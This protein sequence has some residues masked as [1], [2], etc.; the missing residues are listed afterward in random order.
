MPASCEQRI[1]EQIQQQDAFEPRRRFSWQKKLGI[2]VAA[3]VCIS[4]VSVFSAAAA[5]N[6]SL[7]ELL[8]PQTAATSVSEQL[9][10]TNGTMEHVTVSGMNGWD[11]TPVG[12]VNDARTIYLIFQIDSHGEKNPQPEHDI[13]GRNESE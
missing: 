3:A 8:F 7:L 11:V 2:A 5:Q 12:V 6:R 4:V 13:P 9:I 1:L 10:A